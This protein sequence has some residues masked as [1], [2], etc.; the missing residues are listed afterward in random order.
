MNDI[1]Q[2]LGGE[3]I[4]KNMFFFNFQEL[5]LKTWLNLKTSFENYKCLKK[6]IHRIYRN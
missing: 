5:N 6:V 4:Q 1:A 3:N 2:I